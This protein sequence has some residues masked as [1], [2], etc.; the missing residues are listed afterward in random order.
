MNKK[1]ATYFSLA[2]IILFIAYIVYDTTTGKQVNK[3]LVNAK[4]SA[5]A[6]KP[7]WTI[8][9][10]LTIPTGK[11]VA[12]AIGDNNTIIVGGEDFLASYNLADLSLRWNI[13]AEKSIIA[14]SVFGDTIYAATEETVSLFNLDGNFIEE[15]GPYDDGS[16]ITSITS[17]N[18]YIAF[19]D[20]GNKMVFVLN[21]DGSLKYFFGQPRN[22]FIVPSPY[23]DVAFF[24]DDT[25]AVANPGKRKI[26]FRT[27]S[28][29]IISS[30]GEE[31][32]E[33][34][35][36]CGCCNPAHF[37]FLPD[38]KIV[39]AEKGINRIKVLDKKGELIELVEQSALFKPSFPLDIAISK[40]S[41]IYAANG[42]DSI[43][44]IFIRNL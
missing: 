19:A 10:T 30:F 16:F 24:G 6:H 17:N 42:A 34:K 23:F 1:I 14:L 22:Q 44:Y 40:E 26:E 41:K 2:V 37:A 5:E 13:T 29:E 3:L 15:W 36:F 12:V 39:T 25:L 38:G 4:E 27:I 18:N 7:A 43:L 9:E 28:G 20:A 35:D 21:K 33:L 11:L 32:I 8:A 31:G